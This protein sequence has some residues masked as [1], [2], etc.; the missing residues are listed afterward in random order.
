MKSAG[1]VPELTWPAE[2][3]SVG[4]S[5]RDIFL[6]IHMPDEP[7][8]AWRKFLLEQQFDAR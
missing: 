4:G 7:Q 2:P 6:W 8:E 1:S 3:G 5:F